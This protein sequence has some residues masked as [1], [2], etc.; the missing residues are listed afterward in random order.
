MN[1]KISLKNHNNIY[2]I[3]LEVK[4]KKLDVERAIREAAIEHCL[5]TGVTYWKDGMDYYTFFVN[6]NEAIC[7]KN[8]FVVKKI[9]RLSNFID[10]E[11]IIVSPDELILYDAWKDEKKS[12]KWDIITTAFA[13]LKMRGL[14]EETKS[15]KNIELL[16]WGAE[17]INDKRTDLDEFFQE[18]INGLQTANQ[19][20]N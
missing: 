2:S 11:K 3:V 8:G 1:K 6:A 20:G 18:K 14:L 9:K 19:G 7:E 4:D 15:L 12:R 17:F 10:G 5:Q 13:L 16:E